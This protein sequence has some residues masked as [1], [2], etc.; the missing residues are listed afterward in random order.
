MKNPNISVRELRESDIQLIL[1][2]WNNSTPGHFVSM[3]VDV[4]KIPAGEVLAE[5][6]RE[7]LSLSF[8]NKKAYCL[9]WEFNGR[10]IGHSNVN[11]IIFGEE[12][13][14]HLHIWEASTRRTGLGV[15]LV[16]MTLPFFFKNLQLKKLYCEPYAL[17]PAPNKTLEKVGFDFVKEF[18]TVPPVGFEQLVMRWEMS[19]E[20]FS[21]TVYVA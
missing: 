20:K 2:Y 11:P 16:R 7:Q 21:L 8:E 4:S 10:P 6:L 5:R 15:Q 13:Y 1:G 19:R 12:A 14:M 3:G 9:I 17:N 18:V